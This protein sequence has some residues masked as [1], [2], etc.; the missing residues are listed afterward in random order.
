[1]ERDCDIDSLVPLL[2]AAAVRE[3]VTGGGLIGLLLREMGSGCFARSRTSGR[4]C[5]RF[6]D[7]TA[8]GG[9]LGPVL[10]AIGR[11]AETEQLV[12][13]SA[14]RELKTGLWRKAESYGEIL[15]AFIL[16]SST[17]GQNRTLHPVWKEPGVISV[18]LKNHGVQTKTYSMLVPIKCT[19]PSCLDDIYFLSSSHCPEV[20]PSPHHSRMGNK[21]WRWNGPRSITANPLRTQITG[22]T[23]SEPQQLNNNCSPLL[24]LTSYF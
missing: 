17:G 21:V 16:G 8:G 23:A 15:C 12:F 13:G 22:P 3:S 18:L 24:L 6:E 1:M 10:P 2:P 20:D 19:W 7:G 11:A 4:V 14:H 5:G 9:C